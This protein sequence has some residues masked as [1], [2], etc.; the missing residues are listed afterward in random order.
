MSIGNERYAVQNPFVRYAQEA[1]WTYLPPEEA[2]RLRPGPE[3]PVL[4]PVLVSNSR[5]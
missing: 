5:S 2:L 4:M 3:S 1:G